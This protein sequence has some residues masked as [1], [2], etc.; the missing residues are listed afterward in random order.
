MTAAAG[1]LIQFNGL[2]ECVRAILRE[3]EHNTWTT[4]GFGMIR[5]YIDADKRWR[6]NVWDDRLAVP[7]VS[8]IHDH[9]WSF[10]SLC[11]IGELHNY[12]Y[13]FGEV[14]GIIR[15]THQYHRIKTGEGGGKV[16]EPSICTL[17]PQAVRIYYPGETYSQK[18]D[19][20]HETHYLRGTVTLNDRTP[21]TAAYTAR[22]FWPLGREWVDAEPRPAD[23]NEVMRA[24]HAAL[25]LDRKQI[26]DSLE[27]NA[28]IDRHAA[29]S[30]VA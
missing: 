29:A 12:K 20:V 2:K 4:M 22:V 17:T 10:E 6:L 24:C 11:I 8:T 18:L 3:P 7:F 27:P 28:V 14:R 25:E 23:P 21:P 26:W 1:T 30:R 16:E 5:T 13:E 15:P 19:E 9:P